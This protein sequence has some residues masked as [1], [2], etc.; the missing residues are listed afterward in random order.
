[1]YTSPVRYLYAMDSTLLPVQVLFGFVPD[2]R[3]ACHWGFNHPNEGNFVSFCA[4][5]IAFTL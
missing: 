5:T 4:D 3:A 2:D 1:M